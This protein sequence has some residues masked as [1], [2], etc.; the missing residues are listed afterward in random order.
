VL[1]RVAI[2]L[3]IDLVDLDVIFVVNLESKLEL[4]LGSVRDT[5]LV[6]MVHEVSSNYIGRRL[7]HRSRQTT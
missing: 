3:G 4:I 2:L 1:N 5:I 7:L 6:Q